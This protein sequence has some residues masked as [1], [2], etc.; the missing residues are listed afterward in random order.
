[1]SFLSEY[2]PNRLP[3]GNPEFSDI[4]EEKM[5]YVDKTDIIYKIAIQRSPIFFSRPRRFG[6]SLLIN[7]LWSLFS[8]GLRCFHGLAIEKMWFDTT[9]QT[10]RLDFSGMADSDAQELKRSLGDTIINAF[11]VKG[12]I[13]QYDEQGVRDPGRVLSEIAEGLPNNSVVLLID[14][15]DSPLTHHINKD[16]ELNEIMKILNNFYATVKQYTGKFRLIFITGVTRVSHVSIFSA[17]NNLLDLSL[18]KEF[19]SILGFTKDD[20]KIYFGSYIDNAS[21]ILEI[22]SDDVYERLE[23]YYDGYQFS[24]DSKETVYNPWSILSF[25]RNPEEGFQNYWFESGG[26]SSIIMQYLKISDSSDII[27]YQNREIYKLKRE[28]ISRYEITNI[29]LD[30]LL[31]QAGYFTIRKETN[32]NIKLIFPNTEVEDSLLDLYLSV[33]NIKICN[34]VQH[35]IDNIISKIDKKN[36]IDI[37][38][39]FNAILNDCVSILSRIFSDER[40]VRDIIYAALPQEIDLQKIKER[41]TLKGHS[42][43]ELLTRKTHMVIEFK[44]TSQDRDANTSLQEAINQ[45]KQKNYGIGAFKNLDLYRVAMVISTEDKAILPDYCQEVL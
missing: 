30:I 6:K 15:Y 41:E 45:L 20:L 22:T 27:N 5:I 13:S 43:L 9:Y 31:F 39:I 4:R 32:K 28:L 42:D 35:K 3:L 44:R 7:T 38:E 29:P 2:D 24:I 23:Q 10:V 16:S 40:S 11:R 21:K 37:V 36:L 19:N 25:L 1:M 34:D 12:T 14:E 8:N 33:N 17:F 26:I 18:K